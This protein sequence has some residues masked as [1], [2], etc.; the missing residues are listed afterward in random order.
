MEKEGALESSEARRSAEKHLNKLGI[1]LT[2]SVDSVPL[3]LTKN[4]T[5]MTVRGLGKWLSR[6]TSMV[7]FLEP[8]VALA[9]IDDFCLLEMLN[10][11]KDKVLLSPKV[12][13]HPQASERKSLREIDKSVLELRR[14]RSKTNAK[15]V[16][17]QSVLRAY[18]KALSTLSREITRR[19]IAMKI[20]SKTF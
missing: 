18:D 7:V 17:L 2:E 8:Q 9:S 1:T 3:R 10:Y 4:V 13:S 15:Y 19:A 14:K 11:Q 12:Q 16:L 20:E 5:E 6:Y